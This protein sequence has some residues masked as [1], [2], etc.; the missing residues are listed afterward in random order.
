MDIVQWLP[1]GEA[2]GG[3]YFAQDGLMVRYGQKKSPAWQDSLFRHQ[4]LNNKTQQSFM[5]DHKSKS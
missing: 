4:L 3:H 5:I 2:L 1:E